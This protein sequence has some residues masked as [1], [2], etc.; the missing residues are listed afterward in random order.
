MT[1]IAALVFAVLEASEMSVA[2]TVRLPTVLRGTLNV[3]VPA[4]GA[5][6]AGRVA[7]GSLDEIATAGVELMTLQLASTAQPRGPP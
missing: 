7:A 2:V 4:T 1:A 6:L 5:A 3:L